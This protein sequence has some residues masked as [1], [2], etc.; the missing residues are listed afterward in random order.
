MNIRRNTKLDSPN[1]SNAN[2]HHPQKLRINLY[3]E[4]LLQNPHQKINFAAYA[5]LPEGIE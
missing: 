2:Q 5:R 3:I 4:F 1:K